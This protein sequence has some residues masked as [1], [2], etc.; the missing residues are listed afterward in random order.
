MCCYDFAQDGTEREKI[1]EEIFTIVDGWVASV[2]DDEVTAYQKEL[3]AYQLVCNTLD[4]DYD[5]VNPY[6]QS[7]YSS[8]IMKNTVCAGYSRLL[9]VLLNAAG[10]ETIDVISNNHAWNLVKLDD[11]N[12]YA[13]DP[14]F[15]DPITGELEHFNLGNQGIKAIGWSEEHVYA[16]GYE[17]LVPAVPDSNY[18]P[19]EAD[20]SGNNGSSTSDVNIV[21]P[22]NYNVEYLDDNQYC[23]SW[24]RVVGA[25]AYKIEIYRDANM[26]AQTEIAG[27]GIAI[28]AL[29][30]EG[31]LTVKVKSVFNKDSQQYESEWGEF[32]FS[33]KDPA[34]ATLSLTAPTGYA[35]QTNEDGS[36]NISWQAVTSAT[37]YEMEAYNADGTSIGVAS[38]ND[39][40]VGLVGLSAGNEICIK[41]RAVSETD[42]KVFCSDWSEYRFIVSD[43]KPAAPSGVVCNGHMVGE[44]NVVSITWNRVDPDEKYEYELYAGA[45]K[46]L[47]KE[48]AANALDLVGPTLDNGW[49][50]KIRTVVE[51]DGNTYYSDWVE[52]QL[53]TVA[54]TDVAP[55]MPT[56]LAHSVDADGVVGLT[57]N[58]D[59]SVT[60]YE[61]EIY[62]GSELI[63]TNIVNAQ[64]LSLPG[65][66]LEQ[67][68]LFKLRSVVEKDGKTIYSDWASYSFGSA[69]I[70]GDASSQESLVSITGFGFRRVDDN[71]IEVFW[72]ALDGVT[73][74]KF[75]IYVDA[76]CTKCT[77]ENI[78]S[79]NGIALAGMTA[80]STIYVRVCPVKDN[81][82]AGYTTKGFVLSV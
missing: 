76:E 52:K 49:V 9:S 25:A 6:S 50:I 30:N 13:C 54:D 81:S 59:A 80:G 26:I 38:L 18:V 56:G 37:G 32:T 35:T 72:D 53:V 41:V 14:T 61:Y 64:A 46:V 82:T 21:A 55:A 71:A 11:G 48:I 34:E 79:H 45:E 12:F 1:T 5:L 74:Y 8:V 69:Q 20:L 19:T 58:S 51:K 73:G 78:L 36:V 31:E 27:T 3:S 23:V 47:S 39:A 17:K 4:Y 29:N 42:G 7:I 65:A 68:W 28:A 10:V 77:Y 24:E 70:T 62:S 40:V 2:T 60:Q 67:S 22:G 57:W 33:A 16:A 15:D 66:S 63:S 75:N 43:N 44:D